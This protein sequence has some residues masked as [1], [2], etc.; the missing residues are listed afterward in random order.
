MHLITSV[1]IEQHV[2]SALFRLIDQARGQNLIDPGVKCTQA[3]NP[4]GHQ[5]QKSPI[6]II[7]LFLPSR[8]CILSLFMVNLMAFYSQHANCGGIAAKMRQHF[9][10]TVIRCCK[11]MN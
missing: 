11:F 2:L 8:V 3:V 1:S 9:R 5:V 6:I 4:I 10:G 7:Y